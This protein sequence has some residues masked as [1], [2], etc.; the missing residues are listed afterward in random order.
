MVKR[1]GVWVSHASLLQ[2]VNELALIWGLGKEEA[3][4]FIACLVRFFL[5]MNLLRLGCLRLICLL[6]ED[7]QNTG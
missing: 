5:L 7:N 6:M 2:T 4:R 1:V 3:V